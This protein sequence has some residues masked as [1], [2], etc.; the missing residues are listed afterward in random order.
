MSAQGDDLYRVGKH[1]IE[2]GCHECRR[3]WEEEQQPWELMW[4]EDVL[5]GMVEAEHPLEQQI[6]LVV[7][8]AWQLG[9]AGQQE[10]VATM[11]QQR[12]WHRHRCH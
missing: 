10:W 11:N 12:H 4:L 3:R 9:H 1:H 2:Y 5:G 8:G 6:E 7:V